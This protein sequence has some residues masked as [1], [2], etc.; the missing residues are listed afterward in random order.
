MKRISAYIRNDNRNGHS[1]CAILLALLALSVL[2]SVS[3]AD[4]LPTLTIGGNVYGGGNKG[5]VEGVTNVTINSGTFGKNLNAASTAIEDSEGGNIFGGA[6]MANVNSDQTPMGDNEYAANVTFNGGIVRADKAVYGG[7]DITGNVYGG[8]KV[9]IL[10]SLRGSVYGGGNGSYAYTDKLD[11]DLYYDP[12]AL[13]GLSGPG[14]TTLE[15]VTALNLF[16]PNVGDK[17]LIHIAGTSTART[18]IGGKVFCGGNSATLNI[19][20]E[21]KA[22]LHLGK[23]VTADAVFMGNNGENMV[24]N[25][26]LTDYA[27]NANSTLDL[28]ST[29]EAEEGKTLFDLYMSGVDMDIMPTLRFDP[30]MDETTYIGSFYLGC[31]RG[32]MTKAGIFTL[33]FNQPI[34]IYDK[35]VAGCNDANI[36]ASAGLNASHEGGLTNGF[37]SDGTTPVTNKVILNL[38][39]VKLSSRELAYNAGSDTYTLEWKTQETYKTTENNAEV[40]VPGLALGNVYGGCYNS[41]I[42]NGSVLINID[43]NLIATNAK[44][45]S[46]GG[47]TGFAT[48]KP[49]DN[50]LNSNENPMRDDHTNVAFSVFGG[51]YGEK[52]EILGNT[53]INISDEGNI[54]RV[55]GGGQKG[56][57]GEI[58][59]SGSGAY[60]D[61]YENFLK[62]N[63]TINLTSGNVGVVYGGGYEG[64]VTGNTTVNLLGGN[65]YVT[66]GGACNAYI[67]GYAQTFVG[68]NSNGTASGLPKVVNSVFGGNDLGGG[69]IGT[70]NFSSRVSN[71]GTDGTLTKVYGYDATSNP[72][73]DVLKA[74]AYVEYRKGSVGGA[75][76]GGN[77]GDYDYATEFSTYT[78]PQIG[79]AFVNF[80]PVSDNANKVPKIYGGS[81]GHSGGTDKNAMQNRSYV[82]IDIPKVTTEEGHE[83]NQEQFTGTEVFGAGE[84]AGLGMRFTPDAA[85]AAPDEA[86]TVIDLI[87][88][89]IA[90]AYGGSYQ[91]GVTRRTVVNVP[92]GST[93][94]LPKIFGGAYGVSN[95]APCD[96]Y[97]SHVNYASSEARTNILYGGN[98]AFRRTLYAQVNVSDTVIQLNN[99]YN[100]YA[101]GAGYGPNS[102]ARYTEVNIL[103]KGLVYEAY[104]GGQ[105]GMV[106][107]KLSEAYFAD[108]NSYSL[109]L[110]GNG[111]DGYDYLE[112]G[113]TG[114]DNSLAQVAPVYT[115]LHNDLYEENAAIQQKFNTNVHIYEGGYIGNYAY[116]GGYG[117][118][119]VVS[120]STYIDLLGGQVYKDIYAGGTSGAVRDEYR[121]GTFTASA[122]AYIRGGTVRNVYGAGWKGDIGYS[123]NTL[124][125]PGATNV[126][127][128]NLIGSTYLN[129]IPAIQRNAYAGGEGEQKNGVTVGSSVYGTANITLYNGY[130]G[131]TYKN[132]L[133]NNAVYD[134]TNYEEK[135]D[136][137]TAEA[138]KQ[139]NALVKAGNIFGSGYVDDS[140]ADFTKVTVYGGVVRN[141]VYGGGEIGT[142]GRGT[143]TVSAGDVVTIGITKAGRTNVYVYGG[144]IRQ[145]V[146]G[147]GRGYDNLD[148]S[149]EFGT[150]GYVFGSTN[151]VIRGGQIGTAENY[152]AENGSHGNVFGGGNM[153]FVYSK[154]KDS[155]NSDGYYVYSSDETAAESLDGAAHTAGEL[156][157]DCRVIVEPWCK[158]TAEGGAE[159]NGTVFTKG[160]YVPADSLNYLGKHNVDDT[161][162]KLDDSGITIRNAVFAGGNVNIGAT[163]YA[164]I[165]TVLGNATATINDI[166]HRDLITIGTEHTGG[167][168]GD[169]NLT[170]VAGYRELNITNY[171]TDYYGMSDNIPYNKYLLLSEREKAYFELRYRCK[172]TY[173]DNSDPDNPKNIAVG[174]DISEEDYNEL[175]EDYKVHWEQAGF[176][177]IYAGRLLNTIQRADF[178]GVFGSRMVLQGARDRVTNVA[179]FTS[180]TINRVGEVSLNKINSVRTED[181]ESAEDKEHGNYFGIYSIVNYMGALTSDVDMNAVR[182]TDNTKEGYGANGKSFIEWKEDNKDNKKRNDGICHNKVALASGV[183]LE[184]TTEES[185]RENKV[186]G[187][188]TGV[189]QLDL[190]N[191]KTGLG[192]GYVYAKN[193]HGTRQPSG[194]DRTLL[195]PYNKANTAH[196]KAVTN[197][198]YDYTGDNYIETSGNFIHNRKQIIDDCYPVGGRHSGATASAGHY[199]FI[200]GDV[201]V[202][203]QYISAYTGSATAY[204]ESINIPLTITPASNGKLSIKNIKPNLYAYWYETDP[205]NRKVI[206]AEG[207]EQ[208]LMV[209]SNTQAYRLNEP[210]TYWDWYQLS[211]A[212]QSH[213]VPET[214]VSVADC[215]VSESD[216]DTI[217]KG[218]VMLPE[219]YQTLKSSITPD[220]E[221]RILVY[222]TSKEE[223]VDF[224]KVFRLSNNISHNTGYALAYDINNPTAW[225]KYY[226]P[227]TGVSSVS[228]QQSTSDYG[229]LTPA[230]QDGY[231][232]GPTYTPKADGV[233]GQRSYSEGD[234]INS[235]A[236]EAYNA[237]GGV[238]IH[239]S[240]EE[241]AEQ[242]TFETAYVAKN[243]VNYTLG[244]TPK[245]VSQGTA[246]SYSEWYG[247]NPATKSSFAEAYICTSTIDLDGNNYLIAGELLTAARIDELKTTYS[248][249]AGVIDQSTAAA[250][251]CTG[252][253][254]Y[255]GKYFVTGTNYSAKDAWSAL[256]VEDREIWSSLSA[257]QRE[258]WSTMPIG[259][260]EKFIFNKD[261]LDI[262]YDT[263]YRDNIGF[264][265]SRYAEDL[266]IDYLAI[267]DGTVA[268]TY[269]DSGYD[270]SLSDEEKLAHSHTINPNDELSRLQYETLPNEQ[271]H[272]SSFSAK[273]A[274]TYYIVNNS[275]IRGVTP[276][277]AGMVISSTEYSNLNSDQQ[278][279]VGEYTITTA[280]I[281]EN[282][283]TIFYF[284]RNDYH[285]NING[286]GVAFTDVNGHHYNKGATVPA[287]TIIYKSDYNSLPNRQ[288]KF[289][290]HGTT[291]TETS[292]L[293]VSRESDILD[294]QEDKIITVVYEYT[295]E[296]SDESGNNIEQILERHVVNVHIQFKSGV[297]SIDELLPPGI[298]LPGSTVGLS[299]PN[300]LPGAYEV[301]GGGYEVFANQG[302]AEKQKNGMPFT[303]N[304]TQVYWYQDGW[305]LAYYAKT[306]LGKTY[307]N[308]VPLSVANYH[309]IYD[310]MADKDNHMYIDHPD[311]K[312]RERSNSKIYIDNRER[313]ANQA[314][315]ELDLFYDLFDLSTRTAEG[316][317]EEGIMPIDNGD[318]HK[319]RNHVRGL[320]NLDFILSSDVSPKA[321][322]GNWT[323]IGGDPDNDEIP[324]F[325]GWFHGNG[326]TVSGLDKSLFGKV[327]GNI[328]NVGVMGSFTSG[329]IADRGSGHI[330][331]TWVSTTAILPGKPV[332]GNASEAIVYNSYYPEEQNWTDHDANSY[333]D[334][335]ERP[336]DDF[337]NGNVAYDLNSN[338]LQARYL[339]FG[340]HKNAAAAENDTVRSVFY[341]L[342]DGTIETETVT[343]GN[344]EVT[345]NKVYTISYT[346]DA[347]EWPWHSGNGFVEDYMRDGDFRFSDGIIPYTNDVSYTADGY[348]PVF[349]DDYI[350]FGQVLSYDLYDSNIRPTHDT[351]P[352]G[353]VKDHTLQSQDEVDN[354]RHLLLT[355]DS[356]T[357]NRLYRAPAYYRNGTFGKSVIFNASA[358]FTGESNK[359]LTAIDFSG[360]GDITGYQGVVPGKPADYTVRNEGY[361]P[362]LD[363]YGLDGFITDGITKNLLAYTPDATHIS[364]ISAKAAATDNILRTYF[365]E[366][367][368]SETNAAYRTVAKVT[369]DRMPNGHLVMQTVSGS[370]STGSNIFTISTSG[371]TAASDQLLVDRNDFNA[372]IRYSFKEDSN[373]TTGKRMW[374]QRTPDNY[375]DLDKGWEAVS[376]PFSAELVTTQNKGEITHFYEDSERGH[377]YWL[378]EFSGIPSQTVGADHRLTATF[379]LPSAGSSGAKDY[380][381]TF[382]YDYYYSKDESKDLNGD[383]YLEDP[384]NVVNGETDWKRWYKTGHSFSGYPYSAAGKPYIVGFPGGRYYEFDLSGTFNPQTMS[385]AANDLIAILD[386]QTITFASETGIT[387]EVSD[388]ETENGQIAQTFDSKSYTFVPSYLNQ[389]FA[390]PAAGQSEHY[391]LNSDATG[392][393]AKPGSS[394]DVV[395]GGDVTVS[396]FR[397]YFT[398]PVKSGAPG[399]SEAATRG[400]VESIVFGNAPTAFGGKDTEG[401]GGDDL[402][403]G[404]YVYVE[405]G[406]IV[407][408]SALKES[409][410]VSIINAAG[411]TART[412]SIEPEGV[413]RTPVPD[414]IYMVAGR[415][416]LVR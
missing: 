100:G 411:L 261:A 112:S 399:R 44:N 259:D 18:Y 108:D 201:Y 355:L 390:E 346:K 191:V 210:I 12:V 378:R 189:I 372:P 86:S 171:G 62:G 58:N 30:N 375:A 285:I 98:N 334:V 235:A 230:Q 264:Y 149:G 73:P 88:G 81:K 95:D 270:D 40:T 213:F 364:G 2:P 114:L 251:Y 178:V 386:N 330:E 123:S 287:G 181:S 77:Y 276:Y 408:E 145:D 155:K 211:E 137:E 249:L 339:L 143:R 266:P 68:T 92:S 343:V 305:Y 384:K 279:R 257:T 187:P 144:H 284:C 225:D 292:T 306:Y 362:L 212:E 142:V 192:G 335:I 265:G 66:F 110:D 131:Y 59:R 129:G 127:I 357:S 197:R 260:R 176:C 336:L 179:D 72:A 78:M 10:G 166:Y 71:E 7:N 111:T 302:D 398:G 159:I 315:S 172:E 318:V 153:G 324:C 394:F 91:Q 237:P 377:E 280:N 332:I 326:F 376:L 206:G 57:I 117:A 322:S 94:T 130:I 309:D 198:V 281:E 267:Y 371:Y 286:E 218:T 392:E 231:I 34:I 298:V 401:S 103:D 396:A 76:F 416:L 136:D 296:E 415:K 19:T 11:G 97:E 185:T 43:H 27:N 132:G 190:I 379:S 3:S 101:Y 220:D 48:F 120:G 80:R 242:A 374:Y 23:Y 84:F 410:N 337:V 4:E 402:S 348:V 209:N 409:V 208:Y 252:E 188:V 146:F 383:Q 313:E 154:H 70:G 354:S 333:I 121:L 49:L 61:G 104:G 271:R 134:E 325:S 93:I 236:Y 262:L 161:W 356:K 125:K 184:L 350:Y 319:I 414:G 250:Y 349:P 41:G 128:G 140:N 122:N 228:T 312:Q 164:N 75:L 156:T 102:W 214:Y 338:Y 5:N 147:G 369:D 167:I 219:D 363:Y 272:Y 347:S 258:G 404:L 241:K 13:L 118:N 203:D 96:V 365:S 28:A 54:L 106:L 397:P 269:T 116:G 148:R 345:Q 304:Q 42:I 141:S 224:D 16:R 170:F 413:V 400:F 329:G 289:S 307:S 314:K 291:P 263:L 107:N 234:I 79:N 361:G 32:S 53:T 200:R 360:N 358:A 35:L 385:A 90:A 74:S 367:D 301:I 380:T 256:S 327:C 152:T 205:A 29:D 316:P 232:G 245:H 17:T 39:Q 255:G 158:V 33:P 202:Y 177:N 406:A 216:P 31:N 321:Y 163:D 317:D 56:Y 288:K 51:G 244:G 295:Y 204:S 15:S 389:T 182:T 253:G 223:Y 126:Y 24:D 105:D 227:V 162:N 1:L 133:Q 89:E 407:V 119:A 303:N 115:D 412:F 323:P 278:S 300:V 186:Y 373:E 391:V 6:R 135:L 388:G 82:L 139:K 353:I 340:Q 331:N 38:N 69:I 180:Y 8:V 328:Y 109:T 36:D 124:D 87:R 65:A 299:T 63:T 55:F 351:H 290:V 221:G 85:K 387:V 311:I 157:E 370:Q 194:N 274:G 195:S 395:S 47:T 320:A 45:W 366:P 193:I 174:T 46:P 268:F 283:D 341:S 151:V 52:S 165:E 175:P 344:E 308:A 297:P 160:K 207:A 359:N 25:G 342:P 282:E 226:S 199:W 405:K 183:Y 138:G 247:L 150:A 169:G 310:V 277:P 50:I 99:K 67:D 248:E 22:V 196:P 293:Y 246:I 9:E 113:D 21:S 64:T 382:L 222:D 368:Y 254:L 294:L 243:D 233:F 60:M 20:D 37:E 173:T 381:N 238:Y 83:K 275:F 240:D 403:N 393:G 215:K 168:Y 239:L 229:D 352:T 14:F 26:I 273:Q 217:T